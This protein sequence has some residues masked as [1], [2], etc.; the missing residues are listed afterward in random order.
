M[1]VFHTVLR[2]RKFTVSECYARALGTS[3]PSYTGVFA[4][5]GGGCQG[6]KVSFIYNGALKVTKEKSGSEL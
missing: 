1:E 3:L 4:W 6:K 5:V 2:S